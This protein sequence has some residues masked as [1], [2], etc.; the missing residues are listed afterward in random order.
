MVTRL[1]VRSARPGDAVAMGRVVA[2]TFLTTHPGRLSEEAW[3]DHDRAAEWTAPESARGW[4]RALRE[5]AR[6][7]QSRECVYVA[8]AANEPSDPNDQCEEEAS[9]EVVGLAMGAPWVP[10]ETQYRGRAAPADQLRQVGEVRAV[11]VRPD[12]QGRGI[13]RQL[14]QAVAAHLAQLGISE[15]RVEVVAANAPARR[16]CEALGGRAVSEHELDVGGLPLRLVAYGWP[17]IT[18]L[19]AAKQSG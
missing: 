9:G 2:T 16:F 11:Y 1:V 3:D 15:L 12:Q 4:E 19:L 6:D 18:A 13:G 10:W 17:D 8:E 14:V 5:I 7:P